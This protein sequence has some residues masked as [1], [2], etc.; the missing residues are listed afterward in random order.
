MGAIIQGAAELAQAGGSGGGFPPGGNDSYPG[1]G[2]YSDD[3][4]GTMQD[5]GSSAGGQPINQGSGAGS[6]DGQNVEAEGGGLAN[7][8]VHSAIGRESDSG[9]SDARPA[10]GPTKYGTR[11]L[12]LENTGAVKATVFIR[13]YTVDDQERWGWYPGEN[14]QP[15]ACDL[16]PGEE[17]DLFDDGWRHQRQQDPRVGEARRRQG[18]QRLQRSGLGRCARTGRL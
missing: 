4:D 8:S 7:E 5:F 12:R 17:A 13:Y 14:A 6:G 2:G 1:G 10:P 18:A 3:D 16:D 9:N 11:Y 15:L